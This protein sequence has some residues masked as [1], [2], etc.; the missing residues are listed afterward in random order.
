M[1]RRDEIVMKRVKCV[2]SVSCR[3]VLHNRQVY[4]NLIQKGKGKAIRLEVWTGPEGCRKLKFPDFVTMAQD[5]DRL[6]ASRTG[7]L[8]PQEILLVLISVRG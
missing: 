6:S 7:R 3:A 1:I 5:G 2:R 4:I 8:Y